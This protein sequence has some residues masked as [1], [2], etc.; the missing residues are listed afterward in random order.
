MELSKRLQMVADMVTEG[1]ILADIGTDHA[2]I[3]IYL[4]KNKKVNKAIA[5]DIN[6]GPLKIAKENIS[7]H[8]LS[9]LIETRLSDGLSNLNESEADTITIAGM[10]GTLISQMLTKG[11]NKLNANNQLILQPQSEWSLVRKT[12]HQS[13]YKIISEKILIEDNKY[14]IAIKST[15]DEENYTKE[16]YTKEIYYKYGKLLLTTQD[17]TLYKYLKKE[18]TKLEALSQTLTKLTTQNASD[19]LKEIAQELTQIKE[20]LELYEMQ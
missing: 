16:T 20:A 8:N 7:T 1:K 6:K 15:K 3:P 17:K 10:G 5:M 19:R 14:Y 9:H 11:K 2:Y 4:I 13:N 12:L 18:K